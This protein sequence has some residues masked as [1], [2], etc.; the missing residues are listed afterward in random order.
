MRSNKAI[1]LTALLY[2]LGPSHDVAWSLQAG[3]RGCQPIGRV[4]TLGDHRFAPGSLLCRGD[5]L[6]LPSGKKVQ[7]LCYFNRQVLSLSSGIVSAPGRCVPKELG[8][9]VCSGADRSTCSKPKGI[10]ATAELPTLHSPYGNALIEDRPPFSWAGVRGAT[11]YSVAVRGPG[12]QWQTTV[13]GTSLPYPQAQP[14]MNYGSAYEVMVIAYQQDSP[15]GA[16]RSALNLLPETDAKQVAAVVEQLQQLGLSEDQ[17]AYLDLD[18]LYRGKDLLHES[19]TALEKRLQ[20]GSRNPK[21]YR[22][23]GDCY[24]EAGFPNE[25][26]KQYKTAAELAKMAEDA[27]ELAKAESGLKLV[28][29]YKGKNSG[30]L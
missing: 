8:V 1:G 29:N 23:L 24:L 13:K 18:S 2:C 6:N 19:I 30:G 20:A 9:K 27:D 11:Q 17:A 5:R 28:S 25:A 21:V 22:V 16:S 4:L 12:V 14:G 7:V 15:M 10:T 26:R 3:N